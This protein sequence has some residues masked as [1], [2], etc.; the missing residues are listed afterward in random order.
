[1]FAATLMVAAPSAV[2]VKVAVYTVL[3][4][5]VKLLKAPLVTVMSPTA[6]SVVG[7]E[8]VKISGSELSLVAEPLGSVVAIFLIR[9]LV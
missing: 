8:T 6:K 2:G 1:M 9:L 3:E 4:I 5:A 7:S